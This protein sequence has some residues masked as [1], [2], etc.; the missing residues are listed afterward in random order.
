MSTEDFRKRLAQAQTPAELEAL[1]NGWFTVQ[2][3]EWERDG[4]RGEFV[5]RWDEVARRKADGN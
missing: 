3:L 1:A 5:R 4:L 2:M